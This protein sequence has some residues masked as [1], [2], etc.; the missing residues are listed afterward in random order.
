MQKFFIITPCLN[1][2]RY[3][4]DTVLSV[5]SQLG[6]FS[7]H[8][9]IQDG[10]SSDDTLSKL[11]QW[12]EMIEAG[13]CLLPCKNISFSYDSVSDTGIYDAI[14]NGFKNEDVSECVDTMMTWIN[15]GDRLEQGALQTIVKV[16]NAHP[17]ISW[18]TGGFAQI[19]DDG[20]VISCASNN[21]SVSQVALANGL[22]EGRMLGFLQQEGTF[23]T[24]GLW[25]KSGG[26]INKKLKLAG[27]FD[28]W[29]QFAKFSPLHRVH[30][31]TGYFRRHDNGLS[32][33]IELYNKEVNNL[34]EKRGLEVRK[35]IVNEL[36]GLA[37]RRDGNGM[38]KAGF[39]G[40]VISW[41]TS[42]NTWDAKVS[43]IN[44]QRPAKSQ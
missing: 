24:S 22:Y 44:V 8:Y 26:A 11:E 21:T 23:W 6:D 27:D 10:G 5:I 14:N 18:L 31:I 37:D 33:N 3:I 42:T 9:H 41:N 34:L 7:V 29:R 19:N 43:I 25:N 38:I 17:N 32:S 30:T 16:R 28:L 15:A 36:Y 20:S 2:S 40:P 13:S 4:D 12:A 1:A 39:T 35:K